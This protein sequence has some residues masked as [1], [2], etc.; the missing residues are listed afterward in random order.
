MRFARKLIHCGQCTIAID[1]CI[2]LYTDIP[3]SNQ[4][5]YN[6]DVQVSGENCP[7]PKGTICTSRTHFWPLSI[8][9]VSC[10]IEIWP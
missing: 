2:G 8:H 5:I 1:L 7:E 6:G 9:G 3:G 4:I 10:E